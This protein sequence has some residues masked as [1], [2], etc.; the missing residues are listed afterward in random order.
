[1]KLVSG[2]SLANHSD[3]GSFL[4]ADSSL[5]QGGFQRKEFWEIGR[6]YYGPASPPFC[7]ASQILSIQWEHHVPHLDLLL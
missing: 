2:L 3:S 5:N 7:D 1:M 6:M 4:V